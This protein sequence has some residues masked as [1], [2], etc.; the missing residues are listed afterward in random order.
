MTTYVHTLTNKIIIT[1][2]SHATHVWINFRQ[3]HI[4]HYSYTHTSRMQQDIVHKIYQVHRQLHAYATHSTRRIDVCQKRIYD[5]CN[6][7]IGNNELRS[8]HWRQHY[9]TYI[10]QD[11]IRFTTQTSMQN[12]QI[13]HVHHYTIS[14]IST[15]IR[16]GIHDTYQILTIS[17]INA[18]QTHT[19][20]YDAH[21][22]NVINTYT[23]DIAG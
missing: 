16:L 13:G 12:I 11:Y 1:A 17:I 5:I 14:T 21:S 15:D 10:L 22:D 9:D 23:F 19:F 8:N 2:A 18:H 7:Y 6:A 20:K 3:T 4:H